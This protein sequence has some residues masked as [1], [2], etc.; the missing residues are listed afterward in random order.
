MPSVYTLSLGSQR[1]D[2]LSAS[3]RLDASSVS[4]VLVAATFACLDLATFALTFA[5]D[6]G[7][8]A[9]TGGGS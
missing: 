8:F 5:F 7:P 6:T 9:L 1:H 4:F 2:L 3:G